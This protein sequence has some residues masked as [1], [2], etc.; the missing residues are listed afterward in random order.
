ME[1]ANQREPGMPKANRN[2]TSGSG[3]QSVYRRSNVSTT[4]DWGSVGAEELSQAIDMVTEH[5]D[6]LLFGR[7]MDGGVLVLTVCAGT[8]R[9][10]F[11]ARSGKEMT[12]HLLD[13]IKSLTEKSGG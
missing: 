1:M 3:K 11:Y 9:I 4:C 7:S 6:A 5:G 12:G 2:S 8:E 13:I 10:K